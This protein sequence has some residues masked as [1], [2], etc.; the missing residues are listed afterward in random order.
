MLQFLDFE[1]FKY[2]W[3]VVIID[4]ISHTET[5]IVNDVEKLQKYYDSYKEDIWVGYNISGYDQ[6]I[7]KGILC[8]FNPKAINDH[9]IVE[10]KH[11]YT[12]SR[13]LNKIPMLTF[14]ISNRMNSLKQLEGFMGNNI[15]ETS[16]DFNIDR[17]LTKEE[18]EMTIQYCR[19]D[20]E[21]A[22][23][24]FLERK[25]EFDS[26][27]ALINMF[28]LPI[29]NI[30]RSQAQLASIILGARK[31][32]ESYVDD[33][34]DIRLPETLKLDKYKFVADWFLSEKSHFDKASLETL[35][36]GIPHGFAWGGVHGAIRQFNYECKNDEILIMADV[37]QLYP[38]LMLRY[39]L[40][41]RNCPETA[42]SI[43]ENTINTSI[44]LKME[45]KKK[46][47]E[48][49]KRFNNIIY[50][51]MGDKTNAMF[52][53]LHRNLV[54][55]FGQLLILDLIEHIEP[56]IIKLIQSNTDGILVL[57]KKKDFERLDDAVY[58]WEQRTGLSMTFDEFIK[59]YQGDVNNYIVV[60]AKGKC[61]TK[62]SY[63][64]EL[65][66]LDYD[67]PIVNK[68]IVNYLTKGI[69]I[70]STIMSCDKLIEFQKIVKVSSKYKCAWYNGI[71]QSDRTFRVFAS[72]RTKDGYIGKQKRDG[73]TI[74][75]FANTPERCFIDNTDV[76]DK[77]VPYYLDRNWY[78]DLARRRLFEKFNIEEKING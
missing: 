10:D 14:D 7:F 38:Y 26:Q 13:M 27:L 21:Q 12:F 28:K 68:A 41:S 24:V 33:S 22:I 51:A 47:R 76:K 6:W 2:D 20:V 9:I 48:P 60:D 44:R 59:V 46:E 64:K 77:L 56:I 42:Y 62:G 36:A 57:I 34:W 50:G 23:E 73:A 1:V 32:G 54:C 58:E 31:G 3:L 29:T 63:V 49:Y 74:E 75:K 35:V 45:G 78:I 4:P 69:P 66:P 71:R 39:H 16:V 18:I 43:L 72:N 17:P 15:H 65:N 67:L 61:K 52:D 30:G 19:H 55:V 8:G 25:V 40:L 53:P 70:K 5:V 37:S 11:G